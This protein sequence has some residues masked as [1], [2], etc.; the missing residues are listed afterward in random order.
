MTRYRFTPQALN[1][2]FDIWDYISQDNPAAANRVEQAIY[3]S[4]ELLAGSLLAGTVRKD[5]TSLPVRFWLVPSFLSYFIVYDPE[6]QPLEVVRIL[7][8]ARD[9]N[10]LIP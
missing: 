8:H 10:S 3:D 9:I 1:D 7:H 6:T 2:L 4:C 5:L